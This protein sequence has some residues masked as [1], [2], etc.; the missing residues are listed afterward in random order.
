MYTE[1]EKEI[2]TVARNVARWFNFDDTT[3]ECFVIHCTSIFD[4]AN[5]SLVRKEARAFIG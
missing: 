5:Y 1:Y 2:E 4:F 3:T